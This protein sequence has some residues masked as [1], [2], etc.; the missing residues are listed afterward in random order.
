M[1][2]VL[3]EPHVQQRGVQQQVADTVTG[4]VL[5]VPSIGFK[6]NQQSLGPQTGPPRLGQHTDA[7]L[8]RLGLSAREI[9]GLRD[10]GVV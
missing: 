10:E 8:Q 6:W 1:G 3:A 9:Q 2:E 7:V 4:H 5:A